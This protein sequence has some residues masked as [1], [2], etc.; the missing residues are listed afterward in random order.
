MKSMIVT[1][2]LAAG[3]VVA[4]SANAASMQELAKQSGC[5]M[6]HAISTRKMGPAYKEVAAKFKGKAGAEAELVAKITGAKGH[7]PVKA[8][9]KDVKKLVH[10]VLSM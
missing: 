8:S 7:P 10:W 1:S 5:L 9:A 2:L 4:G 6:C 3:L